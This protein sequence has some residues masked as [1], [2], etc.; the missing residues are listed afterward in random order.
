[1]DWLTSK[2]VTFGIYSFT[3]SMQ[4]ETSLTS[5][6]MSIIFFESSPILAMI[7]IRNGKVTSGTRREMLFEKAEAWENN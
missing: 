5:L 7:K 6:E 1:M 2:G 3:I 4:D